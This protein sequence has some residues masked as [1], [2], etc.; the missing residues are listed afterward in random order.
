MNVAA[1]LDAAAPVIRV[2]VAICLP[3]KPR[4]VAWT[5]ENIDAW[6][7]DEIRLIRD[8][9]DAEVSV[10]EIVADAA[11]LETAMVGR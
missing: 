6:F 4:A 9:N 11:T 5:P 7:F 2:V 3:V 8:A 10:E 1:S